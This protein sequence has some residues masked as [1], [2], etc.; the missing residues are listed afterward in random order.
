MRKQLALIS[1]ALV[2]SA[3]LISLAEAGYFIVEPASRPDRVPCYEYQ[4]PGAMVSKCFPFDVVENK[5]YLCYTDETNRSVS[6][7]CQL[8]LNE[9]I[10]KLFENRGQPLPSKVRK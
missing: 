4:I 1:M 3:G 5:T 9:E 6:T 2:V 10:R 7:Q 8:M